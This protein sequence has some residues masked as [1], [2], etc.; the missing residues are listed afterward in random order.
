V[1]E[2]LK[3]SIQKIGKGTLIAL[4]GST[5]GFGLAA[6]SRII[7]ARYGTESD[8]G[9]FS[10]A[11]VIVNILVL[12]AILGMREGIT[13]NV[14]YHLA[15]GENEKAQ[16]VISTSILFTIVAGLL[17]SVV[18]FL[19]A[20]FIA[21]N[22][23]HDPELALP[24]K[25]IA[26]SIPLLGIITVYSSIFRGFNRVQ[27]SV[28]FSDILRQLLFV[29]FLVAVVLI[30]LSFVN[31][32]YSYLLSLALVVILFTLYTRF[33]LPS[34]FVVKMGISQTSK[35]LLIFSLPLL[36]VSMIQL[37]MQYT[38]TLMLGYLE[39]TD[40]VG[41]Y[42]SAIPIVNF[43][44]IP[45]AAI[46]LIYSPILSGLFAK[47]LF[48]E[49]NRNYVIVT[50]WSVAAVL[51]LLLT[52][53]LF[54]ETWLAFLFGSNYV[55][56]SQA[57][58]IL[59]IGFLLFNLMGPNG[60]TLM[61][62][63]YTKFLMWASASS[64]ILNIILNYFLIPQWGIIGASLATASSIGFHVLIRNI[65][66]FSIIKVSPVTRRL[67]VPSILTTIV[68]IAS[69]LIIRNFFD[70]NIW[71]L[72]ILLISFYFIYLLISL[73][74]KSVEHEDILILDMLTNRIGVDTTWL[75]KRLERF[76]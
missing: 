5:T 56:A 53:M 13:R 10:I 25:I 67:L 24:L 49:I 69:S 40:M 70:I 61:V 64:L 73:V 65:K 66:L 51:P 30:N 58:M 33:K 71:I 7:V 43:S 16:Q 31:V 28:Y 42:N 74:T 1:N 75:K 55:A 8:Y 20:E 45:G 63:G 4:L 35:D 36:A 3:S 41:L 39:S 27:E 47:K 21:S 62:L 6:I 18:L 17:I 34:G 14:A 48:T 52:F 76:L 19:S 72:G 60:T 68:A 46:L 9:V 23:F 32:Y 54:P 37:V 22:F 59:S 26:F 11:L 2:D 57:L 29:I 12:A 38:D 15:K 44:L 50:K